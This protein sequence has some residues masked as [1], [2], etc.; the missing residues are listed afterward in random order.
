MLRDRPAQH[1]EL[2]VERLPY[3][4]AEL[5]GKIQIPTIGYMAEDPVLAAL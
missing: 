4:A 5:I 3:W 2:H 1:P